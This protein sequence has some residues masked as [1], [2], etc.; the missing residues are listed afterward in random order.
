M[1]KF[2]LTV[3]YLTFFNCYTCLIVLLT[4][5]EDTRL[6]LGNRKKFPALDPTHS[7]RSE[8]NLISR[9]FPLLF[10]LS[11]KLWPSFW[12]IGFSIFWTTFFVLI[13]FSVVKKV[14]PVNLLYFPGLDLT[15]SYYSEFNSISRN[16]ASSVA[17]FK[18]LKPTTLYLNFFNCYTGL[19]VLL[20]RPHVPKKLLVIICNSRDRTWRTQKNLILN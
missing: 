6:F 18:K 3:L 2:Q 1:K 17:L 5:S 14:L 16:L 13:V 4:C 10:G 15:H 12:Y 19:T 8:L 9:R 7:H 11:K 20:T